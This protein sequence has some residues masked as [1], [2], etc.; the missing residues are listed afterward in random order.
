MIKAP[1][2]G[3]SRVRLRTRNEPTALADAPN[4]MNTIENPTTKA[5]ADRS[6]PPRG[7]W[8]CFSSSTP[9]PESIEMYP[10]TSG[11]TH[12]E[13]KETNPATNAANTETSMRFLCPQRLPANPWKKR[14]FPFLL[15][16]THPYI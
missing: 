16:R 11:S 2:S 10:G 4:A 9:I 6:N 14:R 5:S 3:A 1:A 7:A 13:R 8:P 12:G 15:R